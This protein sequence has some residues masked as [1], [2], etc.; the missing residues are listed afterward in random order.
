MSVLLVTHSM[1]EAIMLSDR[2]LVMSGRPGRVLEMIAIP[3]HVS[4]RRK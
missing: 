4:R 1:S 2:I 3:W